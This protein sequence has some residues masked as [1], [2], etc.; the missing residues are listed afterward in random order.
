MASLSAEITP[1]DATNRAIRW[2]SSDPDVAEVTVSGLVFA[3]A[4]GASLITATTEDGGF[5]ASCLVTVSN[6]PTAT[7]Y[8]P[9]P[10]NVSYAGGT[11]RFTGLEGYD[12]R[13]YSLAGRMLQT[14]RISTPDERRSIS[15]PPG[16]YIVA[17]QKQNERIVFK[18]VISG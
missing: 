13:F 15:L 8:L 12:C 9:T 11:L 2:S 10:P 16:I 6:S 4:P 7:A 5:Q 3:V 1:A 14:F 17:V 18:I